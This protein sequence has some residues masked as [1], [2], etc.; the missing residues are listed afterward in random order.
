MIRGRLIHTW[1]QTA[2]LWA[3]IA[4][5]VRDDEKKPTPYTPYDVHPLREM[6]QEVEAPDQSVGFWSRVNQIRAIGSTD[7]QLKALSSMM[8]G[9]KGG[10]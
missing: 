6:P 3:L 9:G 2:T 5:L 7:G 10:S 1:D 8:R 4:N